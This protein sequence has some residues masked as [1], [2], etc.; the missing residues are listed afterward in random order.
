[1]FT[2]FELD[3]YNSNGSRSPW[4][5]CSWLCL[6][7]SPGSWGCSSSPTARDQT[8]GKRLQYTLTCVQLRCHNQ[9]HIIQVYDSPVRVSVD[10]RTHQ[11]GATREREN[12]RGTYTVLEY[13]NYLLLYAYKRL[14]THRFQILHTADHKN[15]RQDTFSVNMS[16]ITISH[17]SRASSHQHLPVEVHLP[18]SLNT[19][20]SPFILRYP[21]DGKTTVISVLYSD[22]K[23]ER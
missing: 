4:W 17:E 5:K 2:P 21:S 23:P 12:I 9:T 1:M 10:Q 22:V 8:Q 20:C 16:S 7:H 3:L 13:F 15:R 14:I 18:V 11:V 6:Q 19:G